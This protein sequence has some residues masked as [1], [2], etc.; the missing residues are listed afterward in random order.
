MAGRALPGRMALS[1]G[2]RFSPRELT[3]HWLGQHVRICPEG[4]LWPEPGEPDIH[5][6]PA[7]LLLLQAPHKSL[8]FAF[9]QLL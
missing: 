7:Q 3:A 8:S 4:D 1:S 6:L 5:I 9:F 2:A